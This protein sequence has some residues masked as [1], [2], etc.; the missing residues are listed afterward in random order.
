MN[1]AGTDARRTGDA[2]RAQVCRDVFLVSN[3]VDELGGVTSWSHQM[4]RLFLARGH[5]VHLVGIAP[6]EVPQ[7]LGGEPPY[8]MTTLYGT[9]PPPAGPERGLRGLLD[10]AVRHR[11]R[12]REAGMR[13]QVDRLSALFRTARPGGVVIV[14]QVWAMEWVRSADTGGLTVI[15]M[16]HESYDYSRGSSRFGRILR[17]YPDADRLL[18]L[19]RED[20]DRW[21]RRGL[22]NVGCMPNPLPFMP[23]VASQRTE[24]VV[25]SIGRL[26]DQKGIDMLLDTWAQT[27]PRFPGWRLRIYGSGE[28][29]EM[30]KARC[31]ALGLDAGVDWMGRTDDVPG[32][33]RGGSVFVQ[34][35]RGEGFPLALMEAMATAVPCVAFDCAPGVREIVRDGEDGLLAT[36]GNTTELARQLGVLMADQELRDRMGVLAR[37]NVRRYSTAEIVR[38]WEDL[39]AFLER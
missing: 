29:E 12:V 2:R 19:T 15:G 28:D 25:I 3:S 6:S 21:I 27:A 4:A 39:F 11:R 13:E 26:H 34:S 1:G 36:P 35:S 32:A 33:L 30:L 23:E 38:R 22:D 18:L 24:K 17:Y 5:R 10:P 20:A 31:T 16:S 14:T 7:D 8:P 37:Q 9:R